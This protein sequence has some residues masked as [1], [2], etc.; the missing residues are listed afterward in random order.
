MNI[1]Y[2]KKHKKKSI[3]PKIIR[4]LIGFLIFSSNTLVPE[5]RVPWYQQSCNASRVADPAGFYP[6][7]DQPPRRKSVAGYDP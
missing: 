2:K 7:T 1:V 5:N 3:V 6:D 4:I